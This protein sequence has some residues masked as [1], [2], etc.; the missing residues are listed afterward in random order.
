[1]VH[2]GGVEERGGKGREG[3]GRLELCLIVASSLHGD[4]GLWSWRSQAQP[5][6]GSSTSPLGQVSAGSRQ[7]VG[8]HQRPV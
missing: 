1:M 2:G 6:P 3:R 8:Q 5:L 4:G 7:R